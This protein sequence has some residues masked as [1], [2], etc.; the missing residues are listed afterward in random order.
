MFCIVCDV[1]VP[2]TA[3][4]NTAGY[5]LSKLSLVAYLLR[6]EARCCEQHNH[7][8]DC[9]DGVLI[10]SLLSLSTS[11]LLRT[12]T[13]DSRPDANTLAD[14]ETDQY[15]LHC[16]EVYH[17]DTITV[18][19]QAAIAHKSSGRKWLTSGSAWTILI[20]MPVGNN[21]ARAPHDMLRVHHFRSEHLLWTKLADIVIRRMPLNSLITL[22]RCETSNFTSSSLTCTL[23]SLGTK[24]NSCIVQE[25]YEHT[26]QTHSKDRLLPS[27][28]P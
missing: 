3:V 26:N 11:M 9:R 22:H 21:Q 8:K 23:A 16:R 7:W 2:T 19:L 18:P 27:D 24:R 5:S 13:S 12:S 10:R 28:C 15:T 1:L 6:K 17:K 4:L 20:F 25:A 14:A